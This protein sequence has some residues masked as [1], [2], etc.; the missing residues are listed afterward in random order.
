MHSAFKHVPI[1]VIRS[2][3]IPAGTT[4]F[5]IEDLEPST[6][7]NVT[8]QTRPGDKVAWGA[9]ATLPPGWFMV[10][11]LVW[12]DRTNYA[13]SL[14]WE[15]VNLNKATHYQVRYLRLKERDAIWTEENEARAID[16]LCP[17]DGCNRHCYLVFNLPHNPNE[18]VFQVRAKVSHF[19]Q[20]RCI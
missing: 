15:P 8:L 17:K 11:N 9:Y 6:I 5:T 2:A 16:L 12:C 10:R 13:I 19:Y 7:Y 1:N 4:Q 18:Y 14:T 20:I 3:E